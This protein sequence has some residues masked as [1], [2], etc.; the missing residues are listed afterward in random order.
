MTIPGLESYSEGDENIPAETLGELGRKASKEF[1]WVWKDSVEG[2][3]P[4]P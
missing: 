2:D 3:K 1:E 4:A